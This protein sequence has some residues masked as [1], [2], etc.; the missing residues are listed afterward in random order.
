[1]SLVGPRPAFRYELARY[2]FWHKRKLNIRPG[3]TCLW[4]IRGRNKISNFDDWVKMYLELIDHGSLWL[5]FRI[6][7]RTF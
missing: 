7:A 2:E 1:M 5:D 3:I 4:Q 6:L